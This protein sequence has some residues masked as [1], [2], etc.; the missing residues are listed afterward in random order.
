M[1]TVAMS[2]G[3]QGASELARCILGKGKTSSRQPATSP[4]WYL[5]RVQCVDA[6][7]K[8]SDTGAVVRSL[9]LGPKE[10]IPISPP[11]IDQFVT[12]TVKI[13]KTLVANEWHPDL[14]SHKVQR[15]RH[16]QEQ[17]DDKKCGRQVGATSAVVA[18]L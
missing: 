15:Q 7:H 17:A 13:F 6:I 1:S 16:R 8:S 4:V 3:S 10:P 12:P 18:M 14:C 9:S 5:C 11:G 2:Q